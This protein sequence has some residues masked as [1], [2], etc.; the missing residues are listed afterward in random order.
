MTLGWSR[1]LVPRVHGLGRCRLVAALPPA[2]LPLLR[3]R[4]AEV[5][6]DNLKTAVLNRDGRARCTGTHA[7][8]TSPTT[9]A[10]RRG[11]ASPTGRRPKARSRAGVRYVR[12]NFWPGLRFADLADLNRQARDLARLASPTCA[13]TAR[14]ARCPFAPP[15]AG[16]A[17]ARCCGKPDYDTSLITFRRSTKD[18]FVSYDGNY[19]SVPAEYAQQ[20]APTQGDETGRLAGPRRP[21]RRSSPSTSLASRLTTSASS[22]RRT[23]AG[24]SAQT[25]RPSSAAT[26][27]Q[28]LAPTTPDRPGRCPRS[29]PGR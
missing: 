3:R 9:T 26:R 20:T 2:C 4:A 22:C 8:W 28:V 25:V 5:L 24:S 27:Q 18:C 6:H 15:A 16:A 21:G 12:D 13:S 29:R 1:M 19:Y 23:I 7:T 17:A 11:P 10:S 14:P